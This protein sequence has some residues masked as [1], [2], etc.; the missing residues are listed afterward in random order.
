MPE[1]VYELLMLGTIADVVPLVG[2]NR[3]WVRYGL[4]RVNENKSNAMLTLAQNGNLTK[5]AFDSLDI[6]FIIAP[7]INALGR[8]S[9]P[10]DAVKFMI[11]ADTSRY[12][13][14]WANFKN[15]E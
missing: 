15:N 1:K 14:H 3:F 12:R 6:G 11:S 13:S 2:E 10:R 5:E 9:D 8:L 7:Q 4:H